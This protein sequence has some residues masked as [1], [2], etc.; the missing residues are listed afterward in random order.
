MCAVALVMKPGDV[1]FGEGIERHKALKQWKAL[2]PIEV[3]FVPNDNL[4]YLVVW[5]G[6]LPIK[7]GRGQAESPATH[8]IPGVPTCRA[9]VKP[10]SAKGPPLVN[11][12]EHW[13]AGCDRGGVRTPE[14]LALRRCRSWAS[15]LRTACEWRKA[16]M[17]CR[18]PHPPAKWTGNVARAA[19]ANTHASSRRTS[20]RERAPSA[21]GGAI[22]FRPEPKPCSCSEP[23]THGRDASSKVLGAR[24]ECA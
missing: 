11:G 24:R 20:Q 17:W 23:S 12:L 13:E 22:Q 18:L 3:H 4:S 5:R 9:S 15:P 6:H 21:S 7:V 2:V 10:P 1:H 19:S 14:T 16:A 8:P